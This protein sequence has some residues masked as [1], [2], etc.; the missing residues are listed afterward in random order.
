M[1]GLEIQEDNDLVFSNESFT[2][3]TTDLFARMPRVLVDM[4]LSYLERKDVA[5]IREVSRSFSQ[6]PQS[7]FR[8]CVRTEMPWVWEVAVDCSSD[9]DWHALWCRLAAADGGDRSDENERKWLSGVRAE[10]ML[11][12]KYACKPSKHS[13]GVFQER[14]AQAKREAE[15]EIEAGYANGMWKRKELREVRGLRNRRRIWECCQQLVER[16]D[17]LPPDAES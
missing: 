6:L 14:V 9:L 11:H 10:K 12:V 7:Y 17:A 16:I 5:A 13:Y 1:C 4:L 3:N 15:E 2:V 8:R